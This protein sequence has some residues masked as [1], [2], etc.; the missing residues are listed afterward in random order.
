MSASAT[1]RPSSRIERVGRLRLPER[2]RPLGEDR[3][4][5][6]LGVHAMDGDP[7]LLVSLADRPR[8]RQRAAMPR[9][10]RG[11]AVEPAEPGHGERVG[12]DLPRKAHA[13]D[14]V[15]LRGGEQRRNRASARRQEHVELGC[16]AHHEFSDLGQ[17]AV[18]AVVVPHRQERDRLVPGSSHDGVEAREHRRDAGHDDDAPA[19]SSRRIRAPD[20]WLRAL[21]TISST[22]TCHGRVSAKTMHSAM[23]SGRNGSTPR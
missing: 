6:E 4:G 16:G 12:R 1:T 21:T 19:H 10:Q 3:P 7:D 2:I 22:F 14:E 11:M 23:S 20:A 5:V 13:D 15:G 9:Q 8:D 18:A 17:I